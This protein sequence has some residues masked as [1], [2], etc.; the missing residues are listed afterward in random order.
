MKKF[1]CENCFEDK[2]CIYE[3]GLINEKID[4]IEIKYLSKFYVCKD[5]GSKIYGDMFDYNVREANR[6]LREKTGLITIEE[7]EKIVEKYSIGKKPLSLILGL[8]EVTVMRYLN[9]QNP[10]KDNSDLL[11]NI[12]SNPFLYEIFLET[13]KDKIT[14]VAYKKSL[15]KTKQIE[16]VSDNSELYNIAL[17]FINKSEELDPLSLQ[18]ILYFADGFSNIFLNKKIFNT[19]AEAWK[20]GPV[21]KDIYDCF[22][23]YQ[24]NKI[25]YGEILNN[26]VFNF[27]V[28]EIEYLNSILENFG[29][30]SGAILREMTHLTDPWIKS[31]EG[32]DENEPSCRQI[33]NE[34]MKDYFDNV[35]KEYNISSIHDIKNYSEALFKE[36]K[37]NLFNN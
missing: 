17:Y 12:L 6:K 37:K 23:Y 31:R 7:I 19:Q 24:Y 11:K 8:G 20:Y 4:G 27:T 13:N 14:D 9:G 16:L 25:D 33:S 22:S 21:Y 28:D 35:C 3:E 26:R 10:T 15:G 32:L 36:A 30:Y 1:F 18:K 29:C 5:C 34:D 2:E